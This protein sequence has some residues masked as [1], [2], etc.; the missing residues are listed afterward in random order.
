VASGLAWKVISMSMRTQTGPVDPAGTGSGPVAH[1]G[2]DPARQGGDAVMEDMPEWS[3]LIDPR[4]LD[5]T[6]DKIMAAGGPLAL[7][8]RGGFLP[9]LVKTVLER[10]LQA[11]LS[12]HLGYDK[13][14]RA[15]A[16]SGNNRNGATPKTVRSE[17][18]PVRLA[19]P[20][21]RNASFAPATGR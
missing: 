16:G 8:G 1:G 19:V 20:R 10:G 17:V 4:T 15:G 11:E 13:G 14:E 2:G 12:G 18:G 3:D 5:D 7:T 21:D 6:I 9:S